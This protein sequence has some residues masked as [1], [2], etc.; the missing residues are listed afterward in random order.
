MKPEHDGHFATE[1]Q[2]AYLHLLARSQLRSGA[3]HAMDASDIVQQTLLQA[4]QKREQ[5]RGQTEA[6]FRGW[7]RQIL[8]NVIADAFR[9]RVPKAVLD[10]LNQSAAQ[11][12]HFLQSQPTSPSQKVERGE[13]LARLVKALEDMPEDERTAIELRHF[14]QPAWPLEKIAEHLGR[15]TPKAVASLLHRGLERLREALSEEWEKN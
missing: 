5:F 1:H 7:L 10:D 13:L 2:R 4:H 11:L 6:E 3:N 15:P 12:D 9:K 14:E 8:A